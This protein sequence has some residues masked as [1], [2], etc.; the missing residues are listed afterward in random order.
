[1]SGMRPTSFLNKATQQPDGFCVDAMNAIGKRAGLGVSY[2]YAGDWEEVEKALRSGQADLCPMLAVTDKRKEH[3]FYTAS[4]ET[5][6][7]TI[8]VRSSTRDIRG[9]DDLRGRGV[10]VI[11][12]S[13][14]WEL[15][16]DLPDVRLISYRALQAA[17]F[18]LLAGRVDAFVAP[19]NNILAVARELGVES[20]VRLLAPLRENRRAIAVRRDRP[21]LYER[22]AGVVPGFIDSPEYHALYLKWYGQADPFWSAG[23]VAAG[24]ALLL[25]A[26]A[27]GLVVWRYSATIRLSRQLRRAVALHGETE[28]ALRVQRQ[29]ID[30]IVES[31]QEW[32]WAIDPQGVHTFSNPAGE[33]ILGYRREDLIGR[34]NF[35]L[36][37]EDDRKK[38]E[39]LLPDF[40]N[41]K[42]GWNG[43]L[44]RWR[45]KDGSYRYLES[46]AVPILDAQGDLRGFRGVDRD[47]TERHLAEDALR[48]SVSL[49]RAT[50]E[51]TADGILVVD[52]S[53]RITGFNRRFA[54]LWGIPDNILEMHDDRRALD[55]VTEQVRDPERFLAKVRELYDHPEADSFDTIEFND[56][57][58][59]ERYSQPHRLDGRPVGRVWSFRDVTRRKQV[60]REREEL[61][62]QLHQAQKMEAMGQLAGGVAHDF[63]NLLTVILSNIGAIERAFPGNGTVR[64]AVGVIR[65]AASQAVGVTQS[66]LT[67]SRHL[68]AEKRSTQLQGIVGNVT[69]MLRR[70]MPASIEIIVDV[71]P[72]PV[73]WVLA[74]A[75]Q[76]QQVL[77]N[78]AINARDAMPGGGTLRISAAACGDAGDRASESPNRRF[79]CV[80]V[81][82]TGSG[83][84]EQV[85]ARMFEPFFTTK[86]RGEGTGLGLSIVHG[87]IQNHDGRIDV[88][89]EIGKGATFRIFLP[90]ADPDAGEAPRENGVVDRGRGET[91]LLAEDNLFVRSTIVSMLQGLGYEMI[92]VP[93]G[94]AL[95][96]SWD[97]HRERARLLILDVDLPGRSGVDCLRAIRDEGASVPVVLITGSADHR[98]E[99]EADENTFPLH[100]PF[101][102]SQLTFLVGKLMGHTAAEEAKH[103]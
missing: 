92:A 62:E 88:E 102:M 9:I 39:S 96:T 73:L 17:F 98:I 76:L 36:L 74:D 60:E 28:E 31:S 80:T 84:S 38:V 4:I 89:T 72:K 65:S 82:D 45:H 97:M 58:V 41:R 67:L 77:L 75:V 30:A 53:G 8:A 34:T 95:M 54:Q 43:L 50:I 29:T 81:S 40:I 13:Q 7:I 87:I 23:R 61:Q 32:I 59:F 18:D 78:L 99:D 71:S 93:D 10:A 1:M 70:L 90:M 44:L 16:T 57:R 48:Q 66:L 47:I 3:V 33:R 5:Y 14:A 91:I 52:R 86:P 68:P 25:F 51:S 11:R 83:I 15:L 63:N 20:R 46:N 6:A 64:E 21:A 55:Y 101:E 35:E 26:V 94:P 27:G 100:K 37:H 19:D 22:I 85:R 69:R 49:L 12:G 103:D 79:A 2:L 24:M 42:C 56:G